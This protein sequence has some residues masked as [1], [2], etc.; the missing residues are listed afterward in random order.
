MLV[1]LKSLFLNKSCT[2]K[3]LTIFR[4]GLLALIM[5]SLVSGF[6]AAF[7]SG[8]KG[9]VIVITV[10][11]TIN[12]ATDEF[13]QSALEHA[14][15]R[16]ARL[17]VFK[18]NTPGGLLVSTQGMVSSIMESKVPVAVYVSPSGGSATSAGVFVTMSGHIAAMAPSTTIGA[19]HPVTGGGGDL[20]GDMREKI[21][22]FSASQIKAIAERRGRNVKWAEKAV[23]ESVSITSRE[24]LDEHVIDF[25]AS[26]LERVLEK[27]EGRTVQ[28]AGKS[29]T[30]E[31]L[32]EAPREVF[33]MSWRQKIVNVLVD[34]NIAIL[35]GLGAILGIGIELYHPGAALPGLVGVICLLL[36]LASSQVLPINYTGAALLVLGLAFFMVEMFVPAF[37]AWGGAGIVCLVLGS[38]YFLKDD[39]IYGTGISVNYTLIVTFAVTAGL[40]LLGA[41]YLAVGAQR[42]RVTTGKKGLIGQ[43]GSVKVKFDADA[44]GQYC[45]KV[46]VNGELWQAFTKSGDISLEIGERVKVV[47]VA[48]GM[49]LVV[50]K[51]S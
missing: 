15:R 1:D 3:R 34:P 32:K 49:R 20:G 51:T 27:S 25:I 31:G 50:E 17:L 41:V 47:E 8:G 48:S 18:L 37:G 11:G 12:P 44:S 23:R 22:N 21:E 26:D 46:F 13:L 35:L 39:M 29:V 33:E 42:R 2:S 30:L 7:A 43:T 4:L 24:A 40:I 5:L 9:P 19:A 36:S 14:R 38:V 6:G 28:L 10:D 45:G 16:D